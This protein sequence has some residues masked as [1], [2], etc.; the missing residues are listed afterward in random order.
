MDDL[1]RESIKA[2]IA[3]LKEAWK[4]LALAV[5]SMNNNGDFY[6][7]EKATKLY[8]NEIPMRASGPSGEVLGATIMGIYNRW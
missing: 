1:E 7:G 6:L 3:S 4:L 2:E 5:I 8:K